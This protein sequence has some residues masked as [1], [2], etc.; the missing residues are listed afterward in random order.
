MEYTSRN[1]QTFGE[2]LRGHRKQKRLTQRNLAE[3]MDV[4]Y[5]TIYRWEQGDF[6]PETRGIILELAKQLN[7]NKQETGQLLEASLFPVFSYW[8]VPHPR[9][10]FF[11]GREDILQQLTTIL[12]TAQIP[13]LSKSCALSGLGGIGKTQTAIEYAHRRALDYTAVFWI[14]AETTESLFSSAMAI[15]HLLNLPEGQEPEEQ[16]V[17]TAVIRWLSTHDNWLLIL[18]NVENIELVKGFLPAARYG[19]LLLTTRRQALGITSSILDLKPLTAEEGQQF[20]LR[21]ARRL[22]LT[23][24]ET[25]SPHLSPSTISEA[26]ILVEYLEGLPLALEQAGAYI[27]ETGCSV[28]EYLQRYSTQRKH[29]LA[30]RGLHEGVHPASVT[31]TLTLSVQQVDQVHPAAVEL[32]RFCAFLY[33]DAIP[34]DLFREGASLVGVRLDPVVADPYQ[35]DL[36]LAALRSA[37]LVTRSPETRTLSLHRLV[38]A[39]LQDQMDITE[40]RMWSERVVRMLHAVFPDGEVAGNWARCEQYIAQALVCVSL[41]EHAECALPEAGEL[42]FKAGSYLVE[43]GRYLEAEPLLVQAIALGERQ[44]GANHAAVIPRLMKRAELFWRQGHYELVEPLLHRVLFLAEQHL[45]LTHPQSAEALS[46]LGTL[47]LQQ[48]DYQQAESLFLRALASY[49]QQEP[50]DH[51][52]ATVLSNLATVYR[53]RKEYKQAEP[54]YRQVLTIYEQQLGPEHPKTGHTLGNLATLYRDWGKYE[55]AEALYLQA[56]T[57]CEQQLGPKHPKTGHTLG[58]L[59]TLYRDWGKYEQ[60]EALYL[61]ALTICEQQ[62]GVAHPQTVKMQRDYDTF[63]QQKKGQ[64]QKEQTPTRI[65]NGLSSIPRTIPSQETNPLHHFLTA[66]CELHP[67]TWCQSSELWQCYLDWAEQQKEHIP[68]PRREFIHYLKASGCR[69]DRTNTARIWRGITLIKKKG[70]TR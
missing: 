44:Y 45:G 39:V 29:I 27:D 36:A 32:L 23:P 58:N 7:I 14:S 61:Q 41:F 70:D 34:E 57:I 28:A 65:S 4:H 35:F 11:T 63:L 49:E 69:A 33:P 53:D 3:R 51:H 5:N 15:A 19:S 30:H 50:T 55:Q 10:P 21:R 25:T 67:G 52:R 22:N 18:D 26:T 24:I 46:N 54:L 48:G 68:L 60:A 20:L 37:S 9:T 47:S 66:C 31:T 43:R 40:R 64:R 12:T 59:A 62:L 13:E 2:L 16:W 17:V 38:Q 56:L 8:S 42:F 1:E 6:L